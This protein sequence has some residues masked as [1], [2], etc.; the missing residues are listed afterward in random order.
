MSLDDCGGGR[1][2]GFVVEWLKSYM[3]IQCV[4]V[5]VE[6]GKRL[7][8]VLHLE[9]IAFTVSKNCVGRFSKRPKG[10]KGKLRLNNNSFGKTEIHKA[11]TRS[12][13]KYKV[14]K[15]FDY[16]LLPSNTPKIVSQ[17]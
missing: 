10:E 5:V 11:S 2:Y 16:W 13:V 3:T 6:K 1:S 17:K 12:F 7:V 15:C 4:C 9:S 14:K 8:L